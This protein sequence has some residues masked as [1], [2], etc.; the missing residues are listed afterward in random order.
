MATRSR[1]QTF[2]VAGQAHV[3][4]GLSCSRCRQAQ[5]WDIDDVK[6]PGPDTDQNTLS[7]MLRRPS[8]TFPKQT[9]AISP[10]L[11]VPMSPFSHIIT[12]YGVDA[13]THCKLRLSGN[14]RW[15][16]AL[17]WVNGVFMPGLKWQPI[18]WVRYVFRAFRLN[19]VAYLQYE[20]F[21]SLLAKWLNFH[22]GPEQ[23]YTNRLHKKRQLRFIMQYTVVN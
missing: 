23:S 18:L 19:L 10:A 7:L 5:T 15:D 20:A 21:K 3:W 16:C 6:A 13:R 14:R 9:L 12:I 17:E 11:F 22:F 1:E 4:N 2:G 8:I